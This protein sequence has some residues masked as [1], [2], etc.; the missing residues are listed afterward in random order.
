MRRIAIVGAGQAGAQLALGLLRHGYDVTLISDRSADELRSGPVL[1]SQ[2]MFGSALQSERVLGLNLWDDDCPPIEGIGMRFAGEGDGEGS[3]GWSAAL[4]GPAQSVDQRLKIAAWIDLFA[5]RGGRLVLASAGTGELERLALEHDLVVVATGKGELGRLFPRDPEHSP[6][7]RP[8]RALALTYATGTRP[9]PGRSQV[10]FTMIPGVGEYFVFP[11]LTTSGACEIMVFEGVPDGPMDCWDRVR[12][13]EEHRQ[14]SWDL[15]A[16]F[17]PDEAERCREM[18][19][20]D[21]NGVLR[22]RVTPT[23]RRP[24]ATLPSG[25]VVLG[26]GDALVLNDPITGQGSNNAATAASMYLDSIRERGDEAFDA[27]WMER[28]FQQ[29]WRGWAQ[30]AVAW[31]N[32]LLVPPTPHVQSL[33]T[34]AVEVPELADALANGFDDPRRLFP[35]WFDGASAAHFLAEKRAHTD[36]GIDARDIRRALGQYATGVTVITC[37]GQDG[38][39]VGMTANSFTSVSLD[40]PLVSWCPGKGAPSYDDFVAA[41]HFAVNVLGARHHDLSRQFATPT[42]DKFAGV[43]VHDSIGGVPVLDE[44]IATFLCRAVATYEVGD[45]SIVLGEVEE[46]EAPGG[47]PLVFHSGFYHVAT[48]HPDV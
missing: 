43:A 20:T 45:H 46:F 18:R 14:R 19:L 21:D 22:G 47:P 26:L 34:E 48:R 40:P 28:T 1:S 17:V 38:H 31:T 4:E 36:A 15:L 2:C 8:Q 42:E 3:V 6:Y 29:F 9:R 23:V 5:E 39:R 16:R 44:A 10:S 32:S 11:A 37:R 41:S 35:W 7:D 25:A 27:E 30:W 13:P 12:T 33:L 24:V